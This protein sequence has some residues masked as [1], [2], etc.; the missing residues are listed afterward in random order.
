MWSVLDSSL[1][2]VKLAC[3]A[4]AVLTDWTQGLDVLSDFGL[5]PLYQAQRTRTPK[6]RPLYSRNMLDIQPH[7]SQLHELFAEFSRYDLDFADVG[8]QDSQ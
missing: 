6:Y 3:N 7:A 8:C 4:T 2:S 5:G 1:L